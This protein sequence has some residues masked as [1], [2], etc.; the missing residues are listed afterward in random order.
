MM[1]TAAKFCTCLLNNDQK[2]ILSVH[3]DLQEYC[4]KDENFSSNTIHTYLFTYFLT[5]LLTILLT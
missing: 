5:Y 4:K 3:E 2:K 1:L